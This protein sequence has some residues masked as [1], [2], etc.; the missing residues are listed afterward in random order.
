MDAESHGV[1]DRTVVLFYKLSFI[2]GALAE[3]ELGHKVSSKQQATPLHATR[4]WYSRNRHE[5]LSF[6]G[7]G[8]VQRLTTV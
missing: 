6:G 2:A 3:G 5:G 8:L 4:N 7:T 1:L